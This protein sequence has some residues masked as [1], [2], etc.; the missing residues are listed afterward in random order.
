LLLLLCFACG[1]LLSRDVFF[2]GSALAPRYV[3]FTWRGAPR[4]IGYTH[5]LLGDTIGLGLERVVDGADFALRLNDATKRQR[6]E[7]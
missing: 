2:A 6:A 7:G 1:A 3:S 5:Q 4:G